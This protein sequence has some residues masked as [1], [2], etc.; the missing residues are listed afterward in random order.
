MELEVSGFEQGS[1]RM[2]QQ[3]QQPQKS[4]P[5]QAAPRVLNQ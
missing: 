2:Q 4:R 3:Q 5:L 1:L